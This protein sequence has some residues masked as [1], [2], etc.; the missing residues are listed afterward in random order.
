MT[1]DPVNPVVVSVTVNVIVIVLVIP[2]AGTIM[3]PLPPGKGAVP[4]E[5]VTVVVA[6]GV[7]V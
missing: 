1:P 5:T 3:V 7:N 6:S 2:T 4:P